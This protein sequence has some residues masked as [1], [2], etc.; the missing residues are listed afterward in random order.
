MD[1]RNNLGQATAEAWEGM[2]K[3]IA[4]HDWK[5]N[6]EEETKARTLN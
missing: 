3:R 2:I 5:Q 6:P 4:H 1:R